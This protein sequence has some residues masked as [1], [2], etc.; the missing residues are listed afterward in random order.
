[1]T[2]RQHLSDI[3]LCRGLIKDV[4]SLLLKVKKLET[5]TQQYWLSEEL[6]IFIN[7]LKE[8]IRGEEIELEFDHEDK[9][10]YN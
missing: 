4:G 9:Y 8:H 3:K 6:E 7:G 2:K 10:V 5:Q 1:M